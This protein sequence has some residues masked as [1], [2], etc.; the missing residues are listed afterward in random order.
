LTFL[1]FSRTQANIYLI[2]RS[3]AKRPIKSW[4]ILKVACDE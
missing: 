3:I 4:T 1:F 2:L